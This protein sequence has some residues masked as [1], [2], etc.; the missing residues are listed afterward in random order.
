MVFDPASNAV[1]DKVH[2]W[3][4]YINSYSGTPL[5]DV[6]KLAV[7]PPLL[8][9]EYPSDAIESIETLPELPIVI[10]PSEY[11]DDVP[12]VIVMVTVAVSP[13]CIE[14]G[15]TET[16]QVPAYAE[17]PGNIRPNNTKKHMAGIFF[18]FQSYSL[19]SVYS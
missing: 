8:N 12:L 17:D 9:V 10:L 15:E 4:A 3:G 14:S 13:T 18:I 2:S 7:L 16:E 11:P 19:I 1:N 5:L 6:P